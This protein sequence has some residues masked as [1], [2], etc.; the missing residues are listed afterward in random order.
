MWYII[1]RFPVQKV[2][3]PSLSDSTDNVFSSCLGS[4]TKVLIFNLDLY[5]V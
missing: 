2:F 4:R 3:S 5:S 1:S